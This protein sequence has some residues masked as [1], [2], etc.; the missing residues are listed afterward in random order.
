MLVAVVVRRLKEGVT[1]EQFREAWA[2]EQGFGRA[3]RVLNAINVEDPRELVS[4]GLMPDATREELP[5]FLERVAARE[6]A[7]HER[8]DEVVDGFVLRG[9]YEV[10]GDEDL[11]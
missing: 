11:S 7:R 3:V 8:I 1:Y 9:I 2:P 10:V 5:A 6:A 4:V